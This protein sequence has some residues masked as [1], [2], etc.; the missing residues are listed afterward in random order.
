MKNFFKQI[1]KVVLD[2]VVAI[3]EIF[4]AFASWMIWKKQMQKD[5]ALVVV[6]KFLPVKDAAEALEFL[7]AIQTL[8]VPER[9]PRNTGNATQSSN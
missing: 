2:F 7:E 9:G 3:A 5:D 8:A 6:Q 1:G 4:A